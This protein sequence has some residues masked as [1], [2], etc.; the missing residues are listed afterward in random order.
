MLYAY[1]GDTFQFVGISLEIP[2][3]QSSNSHKNI[4]KRYNKG[5]YIII[6]ACITVLYGLFN[7]H[8]LTCIVSEPNFVTT[9]SCSMHLHF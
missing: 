3:L 8:A 4:F 1:H 5:F 2:G 9:Q 7:V 6:I